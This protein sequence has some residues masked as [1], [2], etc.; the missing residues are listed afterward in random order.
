MTGTWSGGAQD[1][2][3]PLVAEGR[4]GGRMPAPSATASSVDT[5]GSRGARPLRSRARRGAGASCRRG[6]V[7]RA[8]RRPRRTARRRRPCPRPAARGAC[9]RTR[10]RTCVVV[11]VH[12]TAVKPDCASAPPT[13]SASAGKMG[14]W[15]FGHDEANHR[16]R[17]PRSWVGRSY[18]ITSSAVSTVARVASE[19]PGFPLRTRLTVASLTPACLA[20]SERFAA[21]LQLYGRFLQDPCERSQAS[22]SR[23]R[24]MTSVP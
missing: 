15:S 1:E 24:G 13:T 23:T 21:T 20:M 10:P 2:A 4:S 19:T 9:R 22:S 3:D 6:V 14:F 12:S 11:R 8:A 7:V 18:P 17:S 16:A 5:G